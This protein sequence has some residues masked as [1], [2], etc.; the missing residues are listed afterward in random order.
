MLGTLSENP[1]TAAFLA[2]VRSV[3]TTHEAFG[4]T[5]AWL[6]RPIFNRP[7]FLDTAAVACL[8]H[9]L[10]AVFDLLTSLPDR[11][12]GGDPAAMAT[13]L[14]LP[15]VQADAVLRSPA[16]TPP[17]RI[18]RADLMFDGTTFR[19]VEFNTTSSLGGCE[20]AEISR[21]MRSDARLDVFAEQHRLGFHDPIVAMTESL[22]PLLPMAVVKWPNS[23]ETANDFSHLTLFLERLAVGGFDAVPCHIG[24]L[25]YRDG[26]LFAAGRHVEQVFRTFQLGRFTDTTESRQLAAPLLDAIGAGDATLFTPLAADLYGIK[27]CLA[28]LSDDR[29]RESF[30]AEELAVIDRVLPWTR[31]LRADRTT[32]AGESIDLLAHVREQREQLVLKPSVGFAGQGITAG[33]M[34]DQAEWERRLDEAVREAYVVQERVTPVV[35]RFVDDADPSALAPCLLSWG[36]FVGERGYTGAFIKGIPRGAQ[37]IRFLGDGSHVGCVFHDT[38]GEPMMRTPVGVVVDAYTTGNLLPAAFDQHGVR[39]VHVQAAREVS[40]ALPGPDMARFLDNIVYDGE[41]AVSRIG[42]LQPLCVIAGQDCGVPLADLLNERLGLPG[43]GS[44]LSIARGDKYRMIEQLRE[45]SV[46]CAQQFK[47]A[48]PAE[49]VRWA[50]DNQLDRAV[51]KPLS[52]AGT[53]RVYIC[54]GDAEIAAAAHAVLSGPDI[55]GKPN[56]EALIQSFLEG[57][58]YIVDTVSRDGRR[59]V[60]GVWRYHKRILTDGRPVYDRDVLLAAD[61]DPV[62]ELIAYVDTVLDALGIRYGSAHAEVIMTADG[63]ALVE[64]GARMNGNMNPGFHDRCLGHNQANLTA[65]AYLHPEQFLAEYADRAYTRNAPAMVCNTATELDGVVDFVDPAAVARIE[66]LPSVHSV[67]VKLRPGARIRPTR[68]LLSSPLRVFMTGGTEADILADYATLQGIKDD[69]YRVGG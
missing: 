12:F 22:S 26:K 32:R 30:T 31:Y 38:S 9:D 65:L 15:R 39:L 4:S 16:T 23:P 45:R 61:E 13:A 28:L 2:D 50:N 42:A 69:V 33:W 24:Q 60:C 56:T 53:D 29:H 57:N 68:D 55:Y 48:D 46:R 54:H 52:S 66:A 27:E 35:E 5:H 49:L 59:F 10:A 37:D 8:D 18:G 14:G 47:S 17:A 44:A 51:V 41:L 19:L 25:E 43:N 62:P 6:K 40:S 58:E 7:A 34:V 1:T 67:A 36:A 20:V 63:P 64:I 11:L 3:D 21:A